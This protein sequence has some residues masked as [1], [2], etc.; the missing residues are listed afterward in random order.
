ML[1]CTS[2]LSCA[3]V[4]IVVAVAVAVMLWQTEKSFGLSSVIAV[5]VY[6]TSFAIC[7]TLDRFI[8]WLRR[9]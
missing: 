2:R 4:S 6:F 7:S 9:P 5:V 1:G 8:Q 3:S